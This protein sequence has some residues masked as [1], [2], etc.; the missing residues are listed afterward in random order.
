MTRILKSYHKRNDRRNFPEKYKQS[1]PLEKNH[2]AWL[3]KN[4]KI[5]FSQLSWKI[6]NNSRSPAF[7][8]LFYQ[9]I[10]FLFYQNIKGFDWVMNL[11]S[12]VM[13]CQKSV[14]PAKT[15]VIFLWYYFLTFW[16]LNDLILSLLNLLTPV[17]TK[18]CLAFFKILLASDLW[19]TVDC[20]C[21]FM[22]DTHTF[23]SCYY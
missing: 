11:L 5:L 9:N 21:C 8:N 18:F 1:M 6:S 7:R 14:F 2:I 22:G 19:W 3:V 16:C 17:V 13:F 4:G 20:T 23:E 10:N 12:W 15:T